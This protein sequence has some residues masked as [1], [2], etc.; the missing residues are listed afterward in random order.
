MQVAIWGQSGDGGVEHGGHDLGARAD[1]E[2]LGVVVHG[3]A[4]DRVHGPNVPVAAGGGGDDLGRCT[5]VPA[6]TCR[7][8]RQQR[9]PGVFNGAY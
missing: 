8:Q 3:D 7:R 2:P 9:Y 1:A 5:A 6:G 4:A